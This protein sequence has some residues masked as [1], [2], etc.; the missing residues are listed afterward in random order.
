MR[1][2]DIDLGV[3]VAVA[4]YLHTKKEK[5]RS[6][7]G[8]TIITDMDHRKQSVD[9]RPRL[10]FRLQKKH[11]GIQSSYSVGLINYFG[12]PAGTEFKAYTNV[13]RLGV[14]YTL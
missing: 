4:P 6:N 7:G 12:N 9:F 2:V 11:I 8:N 10:Q 5:R 1:I 14:F 3:D 13:L